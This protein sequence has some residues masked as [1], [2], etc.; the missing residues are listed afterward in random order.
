MT[1]VPPGPRA[2]PSWAPSVAPRQS[3]H[4]SEGTGRWV[5]SL[6][7][8]NCLP[9]FLGFLPDLCLSVSRFN[10]S[11]PLSLAFPISVSICWMNEWLNECII[12]PTLSFHFCLYQPDFW[13]PYFLQ[14]HLQRGI[15]CC[16]EGQRKGILIIVIWLSHL[17]PRLHPHLPPLLFTAPSATTKDAICELATRGRVRG[18][19]LDPRLRNIGAERGQRGGVAGAGWRGGSAPPGVGVARQKCLL[20]AAARGGDAGGGP[21][22]RA[23]LRP[24]LPGPEDVL[25]SGEENPSGGRGLDT[26]PSFPHLHHLYQPSDFQG[27]VPVS[28]PSTTFGGASLRTWVYPDASSLFYLWPSALED[29]PWA[30]WPPRAINHGSENTR[31]HPWPNFSAYRR[32]RRGGTVRGLPAP[33]SAQLDL[34]TWRRDTPSL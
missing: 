29:V 6:P 18:C 9:G 33:C 20:S 14:L 28:P 24:P 13:G 4:P 1:S 31:D 15:I 32:N 25:T 19:S 2:V 17:R 21:W 11:G 30:L 12:S 23:L 7:L 22:P 34:W 8:H 16:H 26:M 27:H 3:E 10:S 5:R